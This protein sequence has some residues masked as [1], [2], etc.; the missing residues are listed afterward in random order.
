[1]IRLRI[2]EILDANGVTQ[3]ELAKTLGVSAVTV[4]A[5]AVGRRLPSLEILDRIATSLGIS[6]KE[7]FADEQDVT[8]TAR[9]GDRT[10]NLTP[11]LL[12]RA[13]AINAN[14]IL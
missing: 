14:Q 12:A 1:M 10:F 7:F 9:F 13:A 5:W 8:L 6:I 4:N 3:R 11:Q 2:K